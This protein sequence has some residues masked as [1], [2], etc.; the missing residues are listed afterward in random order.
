[1]L[2]SQPIYTTPSPFL[3]SPKLTILY[4]LLLA[5]YPFALQRSSPLLPNAVAQRWLCATAAQGTP[6]PSPTGHSHD[7]SNHAGA[8]PL[9]RHS[10]VLLKLHCAAVSRPSGKLGKHSKRCGWLGRPLVV[11][12]VL[13]VLLASSMLAH[14]LGYHR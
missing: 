4:P 11:S 3:S 13:A 7:C 6:A 9:P 8:S 1:M 14:A 5:L 2:L 10:V 12:G